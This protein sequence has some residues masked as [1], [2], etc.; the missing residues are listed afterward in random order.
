MLNL[1]R[2]P[3]DKLFLFSIDLPVNKNNPKKR[4]TQ[5]EEVFKWCDLVFNS[6]TKTF[7]NEW[8]AAN[9]TRN[10]RIFSSIKEKHTFIKRSI[11]AGDTSVVEKHLDVEFEYLKRQKELKKLLY[12]LGYRDLLWW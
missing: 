9:V 12:K 6:R 8:N 2:M 11:I 10:T 3:K 4:M 7:I 5:C 1:L